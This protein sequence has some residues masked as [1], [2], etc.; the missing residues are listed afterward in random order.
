M[1]LG[2]AVNLRSA[3]LGSNGNTL[4]E[5]ADYWLCGR[6][7]AN[8]PIQEYRTLA[9]WFLSAIAE[10][11]VFARQKMARNSHGRKC[12]PQENAAIRGPKWNR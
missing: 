8:L 6:S 9:C 7:K 5:R 10:P 11:L 4:A 3:F 1:I 2:G 12:R